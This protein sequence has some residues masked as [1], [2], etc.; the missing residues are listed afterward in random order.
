MVLLAAVMQVSPPAQSASAAQGLPISG[1]LVPPPAPPPLPVVP[2]AP[3]VPPVVPATSVAP[4]SFFPPVP[5]A[6]PSGAADEPPQPARDETETMTATIAKTGR[7]VKRILPGE[8][9]ASAS[10]PNL[11]VARELL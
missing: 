10:S 3:A 1:K 11:R 5:V 9:E 6:A 7:L 4:P 8:P 2:P